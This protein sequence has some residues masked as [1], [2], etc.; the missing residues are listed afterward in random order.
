MNERELIARVKVLDAR[1]R[2]MTV[3]ILGIAAWTLLERGMQANAS[4]SDPVEIVATKITIVDKDGQRRLLLGSDYVKGRVSNATG[5][6]I[7][8]NTG[9]E[10]GGMITMK[11]G[12]A[13][14]ALDAPAGVGSSMS[15]RLGLKVFKNGAATI[16]VMNN[17][18]GIP[19]RMISD[20]DGKGGIEFFDYD[21]KARK[22][23]VKRISFKG[24]TNS[25]QSLD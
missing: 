17:Q 20:A 18:T 25:E 9:A 8:D 5:L 23:F 19:V 15:D 22:V 3:V 10:R 7:F 4:V 14:I 24:E 6:F 1:S 12:S 11:D 16:S 2:V 21:L 13:V